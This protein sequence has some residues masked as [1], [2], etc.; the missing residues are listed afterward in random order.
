MVFGEGDP[1]A[2]VLFVG[3][4]PGAEEE[5]PVVF[6][7]A[8]A[9][10]RFM[11]MLPLKLE[12][13]ARATRGAL[14][15]PCTEPDGLISTLSSAVMFPCTSPLICTDLAWTSALMCPLGPIVS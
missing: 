5:V 10:F 11:S 2:A 6:E 9:P 12:P 3:E 1:K 4:G 7:A 15:S 8:A 14:M 13:S